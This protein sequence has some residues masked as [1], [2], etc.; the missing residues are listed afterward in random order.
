MPEITVKELASREGVHPIT[1]Y[2]WIAKGAVEVRRTPGGGIRIF[3][4]RSEPRHDTVSVMNA[5]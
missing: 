3:D 2:R 1:V 5:P 4:R